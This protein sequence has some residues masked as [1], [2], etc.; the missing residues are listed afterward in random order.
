MPDA[1]LDMIELSFKRMERDLRGLKDLGDDEALRDA[2]EEMSR[3]V[4]ALNTLYE[5]P[6]PSPEPFTGSLPPLV[7]RTMPFGVRTI[8][9]NF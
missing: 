7:K 5:P 1:L 4:H 2:L 8:G 9:S 6:P 3:H